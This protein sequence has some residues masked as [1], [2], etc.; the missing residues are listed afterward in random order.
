[1]EE[2][3]EN[4][5]DKGADK[6]GEPEKVAIINDEIGEDGI[7]SEVENSD[8]DTDNKIAT[9]VAA[10]SDVGGGVFESG[11]FGI[12]LFRNSFCHGI[13]ISYYGQRGDFGV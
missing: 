10:G 6:G 1:M 4:G 3:G 2:I 7:K 9:G 5:G 13:I 8:S 12:R 11:V